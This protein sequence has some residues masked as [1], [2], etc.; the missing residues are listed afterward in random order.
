MNGPEHYREA[1]R[2]LAAA[3]AYTAVDFAR[4]VIVAEAHVHAVLAQAAAKAQA[5]ADFDPGFPAWVHVTR[6]DFAKEAAEKA[7]KCAEDGHPDAQ[8]YGQDEPETTPGSHWC[9]YCEVSFIREP[10]EPAPAAA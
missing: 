5:A 3:Q 8:P 2:L 9:D 4:A 10:T 7:R 6:S 1:E